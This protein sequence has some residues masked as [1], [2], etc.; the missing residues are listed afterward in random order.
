MLQVISRILT[1][2][3]VCMEES[4]CFSQLAT[5]N[6]PVAAILVLPLPIIQKYLFYFKKIIIVE[7]SNNMI[8]RIIIHLVFCRHLISRY[9]IS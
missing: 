6:G 8:S 7:C 1:D 5:C 9:S 4:A 2:A 3:F